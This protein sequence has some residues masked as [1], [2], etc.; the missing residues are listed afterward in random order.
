MSNDFKS[1]YID[2]QIKH[3][4][5]NNAANVHVNMFR[6]LL[7]TTHI[8]KAIHFRTFTSFWY[9]LSFV[10]NYVWYI[11]YNDFRLQLTSTQVRTAIGL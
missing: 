7:L 6:L 2:K 10:S 5:R 9:R 1:I 8:A 11:Y 3:L 4:L